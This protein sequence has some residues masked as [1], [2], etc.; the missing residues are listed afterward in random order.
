MV[1][2]FFFL[3]GDVAEAQRAYPAKY[4]FDR[5]L[6]YFAGGGFDY[7]ID[8]FGVALTF[9]PACAA[10]Y[11]NRGNARRAKQDLDA[12]SDYDTAVDIAPRFRNDTI[13]ARQRVN[14]WAVRQLDGRAKTGKLNESHRG[15]LQRDRPRPAFH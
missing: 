9:D 12:A 7:A 15:L 13:G 14:K 11:Y 4:Y 2:A 6:A 5:G 10:A 3:I 8:D 1:L